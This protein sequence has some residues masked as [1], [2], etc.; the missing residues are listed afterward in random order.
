MRRG[1][2]G[3]SLSAAHL[4]AAYVLPREG[5]A[6][7]LEQGFGWAD[8]VR[9]RALFRQCARA[10]TRTR[11]GV[12]ECG[13]VGVRKCE[14]AKVRKCGVRSAECGVW[15]AECGVRSAECGVR[16]AECGVRSAECGV[17][18][19][20]CGVRSAEC[21]VWSVEC[22]VWSVECGVW[23]VECGVWSVE[24]GVW[25][26]ECGVW[27]VDV[28]DVFACSMSGLHPTCAR[29]PLS[30]LPIH[31]EDATCAPPVFSPRACCS[32]P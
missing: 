20:E 16:S 23:S 21:G 13:S 15:S 31:H 30:S 18:S 8:K 4:R 19:A 9:S 10:G 26:V 24:C 12:W 29:P 5:G 17:R 11:V 2:C 28:R 1:T 3:K 6:V 14:S 22:G 25:S 7:P 32:W 27:S